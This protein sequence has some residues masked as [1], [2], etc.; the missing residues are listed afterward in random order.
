[1]ATSQK[2][3]IL[4]IALVLLAVIALSGVAVCQH[5][6]SSRGTSLGAFTA[7]VNDLSGLDW[8]PAG[9]VNVRDWEITATNSIFTRRNESSKGYA[10]QTFG[11]SK[12]FLDQH[13]VGVR[14]SPG[15]SLEFIVPTT[16]QLAGSQSIRFDKQI[17]YRELYALGYAYQLTPTMAIG[18]GARFREELIKDTQPL[19]DQD[20]VVRI[21]TLDYNA[22]SWNVDFGIQ[23]SPDPQWS[24]G[25]VAKNLFK[26]SETE[27]PVE[28]QSY[29]LRTIKSVRIGTSYKPSSVAS[30]SLDLDSQ[31]Q[32][33]FGMEWNV[34]RSFQFRQGAFFGAQYTPFVAAFSTGLGWKFESTRLD[35]SYLHFFNRTARS[36]TTIENFVNDGVKD[37]AFNQFT[38]NQVM[39]TL[40]VPLGR[41]KEIFA[42]IENVDI[43]TEVFPSSYQIHAYRP[44]GKARVRNISQKPI[45]ARVSFFVDQYM[46]A[47]T[48]TK[49]YYVEPGS[50]IDVPFTAIF[51]DAIKFVP[52]MVLRAA[53]VFVKASPTEGYDDKSQAKLIIRGR[54]DWDGNALSLRYFITPEDPDLLRFTRTVMS[55]NKD[56]LARTS[57]QLEKFRSAALLFNEFS[58]RL[59]YVNDPRNSKDRVQFPSETMAL[60]GGDCDDMAVCFSSLLSSIGIA[61]AFV[62]VVPPDRSHDAHIF[63][64][65]DTGVPATQANLVSDNPKRYVIRKNEHGEETAWVPLETTVITNGFQKAWEVGAKEYFN[66]VEVELGVVRGWVHLVDVLP[67]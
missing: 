30:F 25:V 46:D 28:I 5:L 45:E 10:F 48:E 52:N 23:W 16:Y 47:P 27:F 62:D 20:S 50:S 19:I 59:T 58:S 56:S 35:L 15:F 13:V 43:S 1:M 39:L 42:K 60:R 54:N 51:N 17:T 57:R 2:I 4:R 32:G 55:Q 44:L 66:H 18:A 3:N 26:M 53:E 37:I 12:K 6:S 7:S 14:Y 49:P 29:A 61:T 38:Q 40:S 67:R 65:F 64:L 36:S 34:T 21:R 24:M 63:M 33:G 31:R 8:N 22:N 41:T 9:L 11:G